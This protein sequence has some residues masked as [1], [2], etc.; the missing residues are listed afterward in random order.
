MTELNP[1]AALYAH[2][3]RV[4]VCG[5]CTKGN[6]LLLIRHQR[7]INNQVF[8]APPG[9]GLQF[10]ETMHQCLLREIKEE[11]GLEVKVKRFLFTNEFL[12]E[13]LHAIEFFFEVEI[14]G[15]DLT[16]GTDPESAADRQLIEKVE[17]LTIKELREIPNCE[18][19]SA[20]QHL[21]SFDDLFG[22][23]NQFAQ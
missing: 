12:Q 3:L 2:T 16:T 4:R 23:G 7:T 22:M 15:G 11:T 17:F 6:K 5:I 10:G 8:W 14:T 13:P 19:H 20:L 1:N 9:G 21:F 18:K